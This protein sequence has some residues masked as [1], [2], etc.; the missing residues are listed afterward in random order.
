MNAIETFCLSKKYKDLKAVNGVSISIKKGQFLSL[1]GENGAG[2][3]TF[4]KMLCGI[5]KPDCGSAKILGCDLLKETDKIR[6]FTGVSP[7]ESAVAP[8]LT[9]KENL[10]LITKL[11]GADGNEAEK[12]A[13]K[14]CRESGLEE[15]TGKRAKSLSGGMRRRLS[16]A[17]TLAASPEIIYLDEPTLGLDV[18]ARRNLWEIILSLKGKVT[19]VMTTHYL[20][21]A[22]RLSDV[23]A[24]MSKGEIKEFG[25]KEEILQRNDVDNLE[26]AFL[27]IIESDGGR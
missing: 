12:R 20:E 21:E 9:V 16:L 26:Q 6:T 15:V 22:E 27:K 10:L 14:L 5:I 25:T 23:I 24:I 8:N 18:R 4:I 3:T 17:M 7:Q 13:D 19:I 11:Y 2:K 1:L